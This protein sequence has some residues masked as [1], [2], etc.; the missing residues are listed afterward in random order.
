VFVDDLRTYGGRG[1]RRVT[2]F[3]VWLDGQ[4]VKRH[5]EPPLREY[6]QGLSRWRPGR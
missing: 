3:A 2:S 4:Y 5:G 1:I 6:G